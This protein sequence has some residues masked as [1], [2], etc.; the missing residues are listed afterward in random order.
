MIPS[1]FLRQDI[2]YPK[3]KNNY[4]QHLQ[5][6]QNIDFFFYVFTIT[7]NSKQLNTRPILWIADSFSLST[8]FDVFSC[9]LTSRA[10]KHNTTVFT[11]F[12]T[13]REVARGM[14][15]CTIFLFQIFHQKMDQIAMLACGPGQVF[16][17]LRLLDMSLV[18]WSR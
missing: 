14:Y 1:V 2:I 18:T 7:L 8:S 11:A 16:W 5:I 15:H 4:V 10:T 13:V 6:T 12:L 9:C 3:L 17:Y